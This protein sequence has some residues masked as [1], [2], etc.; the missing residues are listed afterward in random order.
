MQLYIGLRDNLLR[1]VVREYQRTGYL[2]ENYRDDTG[3]GQG[4]HPFTGWTALLVLVE[5][6][7]Y[8]DV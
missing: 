7:T 8:F 2:W 3:Q 5:G 1:N 4:S 6:E